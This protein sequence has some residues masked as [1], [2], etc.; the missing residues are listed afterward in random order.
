MRLPGADFLR[1]ISSA[2]VSQAVLSG[3]NLLVGLL[4]IRR[5]ATEQYGYYVLVITAVLLLCNLQGAY[6]HPSLVIK[7]ASEELP[8]RRDFV[9]GL[10]RD[11]QRAL[12]ILAALCVLI[13]SALWATGVIKTPLALTM[14][15]AV[16]AGMTALF[17]EF[18]RLVLIAYRLPASVLRVDVC[19]VA[20]LVGGAYL[21]TLTHFPAIAATLSLALSAAIGGFLLS[22]MVLRHEGWNIHGAPGV[23]VKIAPIGAL[24]LT[25]AAIHWTF[26]QGYIYVVASTL[27]VTAVAELAATRLLMMPVNLMSAGIGSMTFPTVSHW[28]RKHPVRTVFYRLLLLSAGV[29]G[30]GVIYLSIMWFLRDWIFTYIMKGK[31]PL[32][33]RDTLLMLWSAIFTF[34]AVRDQMFLPAARGRF[35]AMTWL[36]LVT[37]VTSL[38]IS[39]IGMRMIGVVGALIGVLSGEVIN[40]FGYALLSW[41]E[42]KRS[43]RDEA[44]PRP[45]E[46]TQ[47][48]E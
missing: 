41:L 18:F 38:L 20:L 12:V 44:A 25:G 6:T 48:G 36:T 1:M 13:L 45:I 32:P 22:R 34:T 31:G 9:G 14:L 2:V 21:A 19:Y 39:F 3:A 23:L 40:V 46:A 4:L 43:E 11:Q 8:G 33:H 28:L 7:L 35:V 24:A 30:L 37:A 17:R 47:A 29:A 16:A 27:S 10:L 15:A 42:V 26:A 5:T